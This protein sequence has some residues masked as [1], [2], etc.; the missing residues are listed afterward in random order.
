MP[1]HDPKS[2]ILSN[3][4]RESLRQSEERYKLLVSNVSDYAIFL[5]DPK[6]IVLSWNAGAEKLKGYSPD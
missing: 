5:L 4:G 6:G 3:P 1:T 2:E